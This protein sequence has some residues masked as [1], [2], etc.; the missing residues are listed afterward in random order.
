MHMD[1]VQLMSLLDSKYV[2]TPLGALQPACLAS[3]TDIV[4]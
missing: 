4:M 3:V 2:S 1:F